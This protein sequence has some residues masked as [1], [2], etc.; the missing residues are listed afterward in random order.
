MLGLLDHEDGS[1]M[2]VDFQQTTGSYIPEDGTPNPTIL[3][4]FLHT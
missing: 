2:S 3:K 4:L 1:D